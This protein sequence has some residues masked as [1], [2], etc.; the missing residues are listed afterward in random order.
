MAFPWWNVADVAG[1][2]HVPQWF[3]STFWRGCPLP[4]GGGLFCFGRA[5]AW[6]ADTLFGLGRCKY[7]TTW[8]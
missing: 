4:K 5:A 3:E 8:A 6:K 2:C 1:N 7:Q